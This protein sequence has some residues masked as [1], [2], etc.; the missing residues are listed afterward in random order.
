MPIEKETS[1]LAESQKKLNLV[2]FCTSWSTPCREQIQILD[3]F[4]DQ[5]R[6]ETAMNLI[7]LDRSPGDADK[8]GI[9]SIP[10]TLLMDGDKEI[11]RFVGLHTL[12]RLN[13]IFKRSAHL[14]HQPESQSKG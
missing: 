4:Y 8:W 13:A 11:D 10:T 2:L 6:N 3:R 5:Y 7:Y 14:S 9:Q 12:D 1:T